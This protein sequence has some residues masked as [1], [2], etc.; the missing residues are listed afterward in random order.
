MG[1]VGKRSAVRV[2]RRGQRLGAA[3]VNGRGVLILRIVAIRNRCHR[4]LG[5]SAEGAA[6]I[7]ESHFHRNGHITQR[8]VRRHIPGDGSRV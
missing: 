4:N 3:L 2:F 7:G 8:L 6:L 5:M 1:A